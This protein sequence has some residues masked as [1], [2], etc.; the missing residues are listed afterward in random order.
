MTSSALFFPHSFSETLSNKTLCLF[1]LSNRT[2][3]LFTLPIL[4]Y[5]NL[6]VCLD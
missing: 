5:D 4:C 3:L 2:L 1:A 6:G